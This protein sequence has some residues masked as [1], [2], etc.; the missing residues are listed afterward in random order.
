MKFDQ[1]SIKRCNIPIEKDS[2]N[3]RDR[4]E[5]RSYKMKKNAL[6]RSN[7]LLAL[8]A[9]AVIPGCASAP[10]GTIKPETRYIVLDR[11]AVIPPGVVRYCWEEPMVQIENVGPGL[12]ADERWYQPS[13]AA[14]REVKQGRWRPCRQMASEI[15]GET[16][17]ER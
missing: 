16:K 15:K 10:K 4:E 3:V 6:N 8:L 12:D 1:V 2:I 14:V 5:S 9:L 11:P 13:Y 17:N 7:I